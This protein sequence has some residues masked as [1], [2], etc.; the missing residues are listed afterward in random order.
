MCLWKQFCILIWKCPTYMKQRPNSMNALVHPSFCTVEVTASVFPLLPFYGAT[1]GKSLEHCKQSFHSLLNLLNKTIY[2]H[3][4]ISPSIS[5]KILIWRSLR[6]AACMCICLCVHSR[7]HFTFWELFHWIL[8][9]WGQRKNPQHPWPW[10]RNAFK[11][12]SVHGGDTS[13]HLTLRKYVSPL[14]K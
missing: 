13:M 3:R 4:R 11:F 8:L 5:S 10:F 7:I 6:L 2:K 9:E 14:P 12:I 1:L